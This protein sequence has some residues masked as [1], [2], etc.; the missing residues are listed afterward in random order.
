[1]WKARILLKTGKKA[2]AIAT[3]QEGVRLAKESNDDEYVRLN[4]AVIGQAK[5]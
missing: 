1:L 4:E 3:A 5:N 2:E